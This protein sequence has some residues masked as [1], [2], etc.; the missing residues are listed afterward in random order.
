MCHLNPWIFPK[1][2]YGSIRFTY[3]FLTRLLLRSSWKFDSKDSWISVQPVLN[4]MVVREMRF[5]VRSHKFCSS[6]RVNIMNHPSTSTMP[7]VLT[8]TVS[9]VPPLPPSSS[10]PS[11]SQK[12]TNGGKRGPRGG[13]YDPFPLKFHRALDQVRLEG[14]ESIVSWVSHGRAFKIHKPKVFAVTVS[15]WKSV[16]T[17]LWRHF[18]CLPGRIFCSHSLRWHD[19]T[20]HFTVPR[21]FNQSKYSS[22]QRQ[23]NLYGKSSISLLWKWY[24]IYPLSSALNTLY[25]T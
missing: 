8:T 11:S 20:W 25:L 17:R 3:F 10:T 7:V 16:V 19:T 14:M 9:G 1:R 2:T 23:L 13:I 5:A 24:I 18:F 4:A 21:Y 12:L 22:F 15:K 6:S